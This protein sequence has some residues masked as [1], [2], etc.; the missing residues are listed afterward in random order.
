MRK[1][2]ILLTA[3][4]GLSL[5]LTA[6]GGGAATTVNPSQ[7]TAS[8]TAST[9][10][11]HVVYAFLMTPQ[12]DWELVE[13]EISK[14]SKEKINV[15]F[16]GLPLAFA[17]YDQQINLMLA[18]NEKLDLMRQA[19]ALFVSYVSQNRLNALDDYLE[20]NGPDILYH[21]GDYI[22]AGQIGGK[23]YA[24]PAIRNMGNGYG[25]VMRTDIL[26][27]YDIDTSKIETYEDLENIFTIVQ[28]GEPEMFM[29]MGQ[30]SRLTIYDQAFNN[31]D[32]LNDG[33]G[34]LMDMTKTTVVNKY[35]DPGFARDVARIRQWYNNGWIPR[36]I[37]TMQETAAQLAKAG[38][39]FSWFSNIKP[40]FESQTYAQTGHK[41]TMVEMIDNFV[42]SSAVNSH[43]FSIPVTCK[44][45]PKTV[46]FLN[47]LYG[48]PEIINLFHYG[49][50]GKHYVI[51]ADGTAGYPEGIT[52][53]T[54]GFSHGMGWQ[55]GNQPLSHVFEDDP[56]LWED[57]TAWNA[58]A[59]VSTAFGFNFDSSSVRAE[60]TAL[61]NVVNQYKIALENGAVD[62]ATELPKFISAM[63]AAG[64]DTYIAEK[65]K[66]LDAW[67]AAQ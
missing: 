56:N 30:M 59:R 31:F 3:L 36:D 11:Y 1:G 47:L 60:Q 40:G 53:A 10:P 48:D 34:V 41:M 52:A 8:Q 4:I 65:Q 9:E 64:I 28:A 44:N 6:C 21:L 45:V 27:K 62:P 16:E 54:S 50:E 67:L 7:T 55:F 66:Q 19:G 23:T 49:I 12:A 15:T 33:L 13:A 20:V 35:E 38:R 5:I 57:L 17:A 37:A 63:R 58:R 42:I 2:K 43:G 46:Q 22:K 26:E 18:S 39:L 61:T 24:P 25:I 14:R 51:R 29:T 32:N